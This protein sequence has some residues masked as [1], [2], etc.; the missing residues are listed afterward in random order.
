M[1]A[2]LVPPDSWPSRGTLSRA[3]S[4][5]IR[6]RTERLRAA[7]TRVADEN[8]LEAV[9]DFRVAA[10]RLSEMLWLWKPVLR[11]ADA[12]RFRR[13]LRRQ[14]RA[15]GPL[16]EIEVHLDLLRHLGASSPPAFTHLSTD[17]ERRHRRQRRTAAHGA[18]HLTVDHPDAWLGEPGGPADWEHA[19]AQVEARH[20]RLRNRVSRAFQKARTQAHDT[21]LHEARIAL[22]RWRYAIESLEEAG[23]PDTGRAGLDELAAVQETLGSVQDLSTLAGR[24]RHRRSR[25]LRPI[26]LEVLIRLEKRRAV[27]HR[28]VARWLERTGSVRAVPPTP[29]G[30]QRRTTRKDAPAD[31]ATA[32]ERGSRSEEEPGG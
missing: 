13:R 6:K 3:V 9:H 27:A 24:L 17:L 26:E 16:R 31:E 25:A 30:R 32:R 23:V 14:R 7:A 28:T 19:R 12:D 29:R 8:D 22:K 18:G 20:E 2:A 1:P 4:Q 5:S 21:R 11:A 10:R 15:L